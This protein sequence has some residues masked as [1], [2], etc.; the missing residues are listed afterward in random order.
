MHADGHTPKQPVILATVVAAKNCHQEA[1]A[2]IS[3]PNTMLVCV[4][5]QHAQQR[6]QA[7]PALLSHDRSGQ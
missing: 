2:Q 7:G 6:F 5:Q 4:M 3:M 1:S